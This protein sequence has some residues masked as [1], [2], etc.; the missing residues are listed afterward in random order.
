MD[1]IERIS[2]SAKELARIDPVEASLQV[3]KER[4]MEAYRGLA[5][6][7]GGDKPYYNFDLGYGEPAPNNFV[8]F[9]IDNTGDGHSGPLKLR[10]GGEAA[11]EGAYLYYGLTAGASDDAVITDQLGAK[12]LA[13]Q[14]FSKICCAKPMLITEIRI[15]TADALQLVTPPVHKSLR[16]DG[17]VDETRINLTAT[18]EMSDQRDNLVILRPRVG[19]S[20]WILDAQKFFEF[21]ALDNKT[22]S[23]IL[24]VSAIDNIAQ[25]VKP[26]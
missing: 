8:Q 26:E 16:L 21:N 17:T 4:I 2:V 10:I 22:F 12:I 15:R 9:D 1:N 13:V 3:Q 24:Y 20:G 14:G 19:T 23:V 18:E 7:K 25:M 11:A 6:S 5:M